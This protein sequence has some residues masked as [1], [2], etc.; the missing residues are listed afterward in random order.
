MTDYD[1]IEKAKKIIEELL[2]SMGVKATA[3]T[4]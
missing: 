4:G 3:V 2:F 1:R